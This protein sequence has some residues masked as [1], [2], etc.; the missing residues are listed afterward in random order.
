MARPW[1]IQFEDAVYHVTSRGNN[2]QDIFLDEADREFFISLLMRASRRFGLQIFAFCLMDNHFHLFLRTPLANL[3]STMHWLN[4]TYTGYFNWRHKRIGHLLQ[5]R[6]KSVLIADEAHYLHLSIYL[7]LNPVRAGMVEDPAEYPWSSCP[8]YAS[9]KPRYA[10][11]MRDEI[12]SHYGA[13]RASRLRRYRRECLSLIGQKPAFLEQLRTSAILGPRELV[14]K[15]AQKY[16]PSGRAEDV[17][18]YSASA[19]K[20]IDHMHE[21]AKLAALFGIKRG[22]LFQK[23]YQFPP[24]FCAYY[25]L[26]EGCG[27]KTTQVARI[28]GIGAPA[29]SLGIKKFRR[30]MTEDGGLQRIVRKLAKY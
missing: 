20:E 11:L 3:S 13:T 25:H 18:K 9:P 17:P 21:L 22:D 19:R 5:G 7:H 14:E 10:W 26:V 28:F 1:R 29:V 12:L 27:M 8:D 2:K 15:L 16:R 24:R 23:K 6:Y 4:G 30:L